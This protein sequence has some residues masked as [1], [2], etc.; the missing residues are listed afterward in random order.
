MLERF[1]KIRYSENGTTKRRRRMVAIIFSYIEKEV[2]S[3]SVA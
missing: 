2:I 3:V 1:K